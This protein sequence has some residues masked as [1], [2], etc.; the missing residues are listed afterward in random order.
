MTTNG[1]PY[2]CLL[3]KLNRINL[4]LELGVFATLTYSLLKYEIFFR[5]QYFW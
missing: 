5:F 2:C 1:K 3:S 4:D